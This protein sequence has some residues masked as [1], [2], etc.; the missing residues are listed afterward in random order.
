TIPMPIRSCPA[1]TR[2]TRA[3][4]LSSLCAV[5]PTFM[6]MGVALRHASA[7]PAITA[8]PSPVS[9]SL[10]CRKIHL[11]PQRHPDDVSHLHSSRI[12][13]LNGCHLAAA[14]AAAHRWRG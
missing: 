6:N 8:M 9:A 10:F 2:C 11:H 12:T 13:D 3:I 5:L 7:S 14:A 1:E 4:L